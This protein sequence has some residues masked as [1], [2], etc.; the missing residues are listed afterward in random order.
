MFLSFCYEGRWKRTG[1]REQSL[2][3]QGCVLMRARDDADRDPARCIRAGT[4]R[5]APQKVDLDLIP[6]L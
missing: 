2:D 5:T 3:E 1:F 4:S 6:T